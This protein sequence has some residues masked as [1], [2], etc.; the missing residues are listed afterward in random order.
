VK[1]YLSKI[2]AGVFALTTLSLLGCSSNSSPPGAG[3]GGSTGGEVAAT[4]GVSAGGASTTPTSSGGALPSGGTPASGGLS[5]AS[6]VS[7]GGSATG[8]A[9]TSAA[10]QPA[11]GGSPKGSSASGGAAGGESATGGTAA[12]GSKTG[13]SVAGGSVAGGGVTGVASGGN[14][15][16][17]AAPGGK[18]SAGGSPGG[19]GGRGSG[20]GVITGGSPGTSAGGAI[21]IAATGTYPVSAGTPTVYLAG[22]STVSTYPAGTAGNQEG[23]GQRFQ[24]FF[25]PNDV[26][27][28]N[29][30]IGGESSKSF[31]D[32][33]HLADI[34]AVIKP[35]DYLFA[36]WGINDRSVAGPARATDPATT[37]RTYLQQYIDGARSKNA[38]PVLITPTPRHQYSGGVFGN[39][40]PEYCAAIK[41][42]GAQTNTPVIDLQSMGLAYYTSIGDAK[43]T[44]TIILNGT[45][46]LHFNAEGAYQMA[47]LVATGVAALNLPISQY[48][49]QSKLSAH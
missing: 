29:K 40:F 6:T 39:G 22:D 42:V 16:G 30:A 1:T 13:D 26:I 35:G 2:F 41:A 9:T 45:D 17:G 15:T 36:Q 5:Q 49:I 23:W 24:E 47:R 43:V 44:S 31:S 34:L 14:S 7:Q 27:V 8:G 32:E 46:A 3:S 25:D 33:G 12:G 19:A 11:T 28:V 37:F 48:V 38:I 10:G 4:G 20:G 21:V 18:T